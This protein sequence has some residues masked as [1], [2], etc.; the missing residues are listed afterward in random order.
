MLGGKKGILVLRNVLLF[1]FVEIFA[2][3]V[4]S[5]KIT[6]KENYG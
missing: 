6:K 1:Y 3:I 5:V 2:N 4:K